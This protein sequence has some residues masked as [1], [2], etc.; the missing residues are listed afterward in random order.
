[1]TQ[2]PQTKCAANTYKIKKAKQ[3]ANNALATKV[4]PPGSTTCYD[5]S[6]MLQNVQ[7]LSA[8][9]GGIIVGALSNARIERS[10]AKGKWFNSKII[11]GLGSPRRY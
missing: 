11:V 1:M 6:S 9:Q 4:S 3:R 10:E 8:Q 5:L 7:S 2:D